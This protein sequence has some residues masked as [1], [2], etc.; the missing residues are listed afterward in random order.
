MPSERDPL[1]NGNGHPAPRSFFQRV[2]KLVKAEGE[3]GWLAS[4]KFFL[5]GSWFN[6]LLIL[7]PLA[8][9]AHVLD[10]DAALRFSFSFLAI[11][12]LAKVC[13]RFGP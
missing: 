7:T 12:P 4:F 3:P 2:V 5:F 10:W 1:L 8:V 11:M 9:V 13:T 6:V